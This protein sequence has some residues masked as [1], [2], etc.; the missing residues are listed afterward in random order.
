[1]VVAAGLADLQALEAMGLM[2]AP[3]VQGRAAMAE[4]EMQAQEVLVIRLG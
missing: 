2:E 1:M 3:E 4:E